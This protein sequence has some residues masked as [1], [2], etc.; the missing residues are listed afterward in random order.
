MLRKRSLVL[1]WLSVLLPI[2]CG[3]AADIA[4]TFQWS[5]VPDRLWAGPDFWAN[6]LQDWRVD[7]GR[8]EAVGTGP[9]RTLHLLTRRLGPD[10]APFEVSVTLG[11]LPSSDATSEP[12][13]AGLLIGAG[14]ADIDYRAAA[15]VHHSPGPGGGWL[16]GID[17]RGRPFI[18]GFGEDTTVRVRGD[19]ELAFDS[20]YLAVTGKGTEGDYTVTATARLFGERTVEQAVS[21]AIEADGLTGGI[22]LFSDAPRGLRGYWFD[23]LRVSGER[24]ERHDDRAF[25]PVADALH[26]LSRGTLKLTAQLMPIGE[27]DAGSADLQRLEEGGWRT[28]ATS[29]V[30]VP[31]YTAT[32]RIDRW[33][34]TTDVRYRVAYGL[35]GHGGERDLRYFEGTVRRDPVDADEIVVA[36]FTGNHNVSRPLPGRFAGVD[37]GW[38]PW[39]RG[40]WFPHADIVR[41]VR[42]HEPD[43]LFFSGDQVYEGAS[44]TAADF[45]HPYEDYLYKWYLWHWAFNG[46]TAEIPAVATP[47]DHDVFHGNVWG[48]GGRSTPSGLSGA[49]AQDAGGYKLPVQWVNMVQR[50]Q[51]SHLP[52]PVDAAPSESGIGVY[53][54]ELLYGGISFAV[55]EDRKFKSA[56]A[57]LLPEA[58]IYNG[59]PRARGFDAVRDADVAGAILLGE[60][61]L[62][63]LERWANDWSGGAWMKVV[64][65]QT[66]WVAMATLPDTSLTDAVVPSLPI[67]E[68]GEYVN[69]DRPVRDM[70]T[71]GWPQTGRNRA[72]RAIRKGFAIHIAGDQHLG[73]T[74][75]YGIDEWRDAGFVLS[76]PSIANFWPRRWFPPEAGGKHKP[77]TPRYT[78][79]FL[80]GFG[81]R[82]TVSA[83]SNPVRSGRE[84]SLLHDLAPGYGIARFDRATRRVRL[85]AW[86]RWADP[87][88]GEAPYPGWPVEFDQREGYARTPA[89]YLPVIEVSGMRDPVVQ[90]VEE[91][92]GE[93]IYTLR[94]AGTSFRPPVFAPGRYVIGVGEPGTARW[95]RR[96]VQAPASAADTLRVDPGTGGG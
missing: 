5:D 44:P 91:R 90:V 33:P 23:A 89:A 26:T 57:P 29:P 81:N 96:A 21:T 19:V 12:G 50:T 40:V 14:G 59:W 47:D 3:D 6:R 9:F 4:F 22:A 78:G 15:L 73:A 24:I 77:G 43:L 85:A 82:I 49:A 92:S 70:D 60:R 75:Q 41:H 71:D 20:A 35:R 95:T 79:D 93:T 54:T 68:P 88:A 63:F 11:P 65:S 52:D 45:D 16:A 86:P 51:T 1:V 30:I 69:G 34:D 17:E 66:P 48:A 31:G 58:D 2:S 25:G 13:R 62:A 27:A 28:I 56:P 76:V 94:I 87:A 61:Q 8:V 42:A 53:F 74:A 38:F 7:G 72:L 67:L 39:D 46:L 84:P 55:V 80:D 10:E 32:F 83:V 64:L 37:G 18:R 36:A